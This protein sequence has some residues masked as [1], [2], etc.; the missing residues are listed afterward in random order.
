VACDPR[1]PEKELDALTAGVLAGRAPG[2]ILLRKKVELVQRHAMLYQKFEHRLLNSLQSIVG[3]LSLQSH[4]A[5]TAEAANQAALRRDAF[6]HWVACMS[7][8]TASIARTR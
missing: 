7:S 1:E 6:L 8:S 5:T 2:D 3:L 4:S